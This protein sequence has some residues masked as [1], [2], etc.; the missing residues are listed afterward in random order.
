MTETSDAFASFEQKWLAA[1]PEYAAASV[2]LPAERRRAA[3]AFG[4]LVYEL[5]DAAVRVH[6]VQVAAAKLV[7]WRGELISA[8]QGRAN[9][10]ITRELFQAPPPEATRHLW[11]E[12]ADASLA[13]L[14]APPAATLAELLGQHAQ[15]HRSVVRA[16][17][18]LSA[19][20]AGAVDRDAVLW[21]ISHLLR[22]LPRIERDGE[23]LPLPLDLLARHGLTRTGLRSPGARRTALIR[24]H[25]D[26]LAGAMPHDRGGNLHQRIRSRL[27]AALIAGAR[28]ADEPLQHLLEHS[29]P[30]RWRSVWTAWREARALMGVEQRS[31]A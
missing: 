9:H 15:F 25:L 23:S 3:N 5:D 18:S 24:D 17:A 26:A 31:S 2:F 19:R 16:D 27:D 8:A 10:P 22:E 13:R 7:W 20:G 28:A 6:E 29:Q 12:L 11:P 30:G 4:C 21:T 1:H 14:S